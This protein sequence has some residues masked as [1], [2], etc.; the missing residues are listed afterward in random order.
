MEANEIVTDMES[1]I[2]AL[3]QSGVLGIMLAYMMYKEK[4]VSTVHKEERKEW[5]DASKERNDVIVKVVEKNTAAFTEC[6]H[7][8]VRLSE[9][10]DNQKYKAT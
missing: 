5:H 6:Q 2:G 10:V 1:I 4:M 8:M 7:N 3:V 9:K